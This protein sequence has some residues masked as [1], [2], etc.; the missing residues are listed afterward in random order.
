MNYV[1][2]KNKFCNVKHSIWEKIIFPFML[3]IVLSFS[4]KLYAQKTMWVGETY[5]CDATSAVMGLTSDISWTTSGGYLSLSGSGLYRNVTV[6]QYFSGSATVKCSWKYRLYS[7]DTW[8][9][10]SKSWTIRC[11][12]NPVSISPTNLTLAPGETAYVNYSHKYT[13]S[14][15]SAANAYF[16]SSNTRVATVS[17]SGLVTAINPGTTYI[18]VYSKISSAA[19]APYCI[20]TVKN[21]TPTG[22]SLP[23]S[24]SLIIGESKTLTPTVTPSGASTSFSWSSDNSDIATVNSSGIVTGVKVGTTKVKVTT[25]VGGYVAYCNITVKEPPVAPTKITVKDAI[26]L[27]EGFTYTLVPTLQP[28]NAETTYTWKSDNTNIATVSTTG[29]ITAKGVGTATITITTKNDLKATCEVTVL[30]LP[31]NISGSV[32]NNKI[33]IIENLVNK[34]FNKAY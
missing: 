18:N 14:Y 32:I 25:N 10:Q 5:M 33:T 34:T 15:T 11:N 23:S 17:N 8:K 13:N 3:I 2:S 28:D 19:N 31:A 27:Y 16:S 1:N 26:N 29:K 22:V 20:V 21:L 12:E 7:G 4:S 30:E 6:T 9:S 24:L